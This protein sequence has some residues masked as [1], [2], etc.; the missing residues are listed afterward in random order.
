MGGSSLD[1]PFYLEQTNEAMA[2]RAIHL[3]FCPRLIYV[4]MMS[5]N[6]QLSNQLETLHVLCCGDLR[7]V[8][9]V[10]HEFQEKIAASNEK[11]WE[12]WKSRKG[13]LAFPYLRHL[14]LH[15]LLNL[16]LI[17][18]AKMFAPDLETM[19][20]RGCW[21]LRRLPATDAHRR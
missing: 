3:H 2:L 13:M 7:Q 9:P 20:I 6:F 19:Y 11:P 21:S 14:Y 10:E 4:L 18:E 5:S 16:Q 17:C 1:G 8:F 12:P 15:E